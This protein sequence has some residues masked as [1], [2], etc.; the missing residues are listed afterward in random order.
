MGSIEVSFHPNAHHR[1]VT[2]TESDK[3]RDT[4]LIQTPVDGFGIC[5]ARSQVVLL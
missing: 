2:A 4:V 5:G 1:V 3:T